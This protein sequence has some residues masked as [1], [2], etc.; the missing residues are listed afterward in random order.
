MEVRSVHPLTRM[1]IFCA[2][3]SLDLLYQCPRSEW[4]KHTGIGVTV[5]FTALL[6]VLSSFYAF[7]LIFP[8]V[9]ISCVLSLIWGAIIL[10]LDRYIV[11]RIVS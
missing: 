6:A 10:N 3:S 2:G 4:I 11:S 7:Q 1:F 9:W 5:F 8:D